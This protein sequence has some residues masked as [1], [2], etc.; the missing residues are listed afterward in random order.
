MQAHI[1]WKRPFWGRLAALLFLQRI[2]LDAGRAGFNT[3]HL[4]ESKFTES[5]EAAPRPREKKGGMRLDS[6]P[7]FIQRARK[8][9]LSWARE[10]MAGRGRGGH[11]N[12]EIITMSLVT[13]QCQAL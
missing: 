7:Q 5:R 8:P 11:W 6:K 9:V 2:S 13:R 4:A 10:T 3:S 12:G 1:S